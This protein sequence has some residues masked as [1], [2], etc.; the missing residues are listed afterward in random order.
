MG[1]LNPVSE[2]NG[3]MVTFEQQETTEIKNRIRD[4]WATFYTYKQEFTSKSY[5]LRHWLR[6][7]DMVI[8]PTMNYAS[9]TWTLSKEHEE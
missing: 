7:I 1:E 9:G 2:K 8:T 3:Q 4:A 5:L 6:L